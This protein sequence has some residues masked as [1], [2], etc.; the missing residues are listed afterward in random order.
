MSPPP[1]ATALSKS[2]GKKRQVDAVGDRATSSPKP[3]M[4]TRQKRVLPSRTRRGGLGIGSTNVDQMILDAQL[5]RFED[6]PL[7]PAETKFVFTTDSSLVP[8]SSTSD[9]FKVELNTTAY[10]RYFDRPEVIAACRAQETIQVPHYINLSDDAAVGGRFRP[11]GSQEETVDT[12]DSVYEKRH[13]KYEAFEKRQ[14]LREKEKL[15][16]EHYK[17]KERIDQLRNMEISAFLALPASSF[18]APPPRYDEL[19]EELSSAAGYPH[20]IA[21][22]QEG[23]RRRREML[24]IAEGLEERYRILLPPDRPRAAEKKISVAKDVSTPTTPSVDQQQTFSSE[25]P[26]KKQQSRDDAKRQQ[27]IKQDSVNGSKFV[28]RT[29]KITLDEEEPVSPARKPQKSRQRAQGPKRNHPPDTAADAAASLVNAI[30]R[31]FGHPPG[32]VKQRSLDATSVGTPDAGS[33]VGNEPQDAAPR[34]GD[35]ETEYES[36]EALYGDGKANGVMLTIKVPAKESSGSDRTTPAPASAGPASTTR[37]RRQAP[38]SAPV[39]SPYSPAMKRNMTNHPRVLQVLAGKAIRGANGRFLSAAEMAELDNKEAEDIPLETISAPQPRKKR[40]ASHISLSENR[41]ASIISGAE[42]SISVGTRARNR[43]AGP[44]CLVLAAMRKSAAAKERQGGRNAFG[45]RIPSGVDKIHEFA[46][47]Y[48][49]RYPDGEEDELE[50]DSESPKAMEIDDTAPGD[51]ASTGRATPEAPLGHARM[52]DY[53][54][55]NAKGNISMPSM[56]PG[57]DEG[58]PQVQGPVPGHSMS[59]VRG[60]EPEVE[61]MTLSVGE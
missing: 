2:Q 53:E 46:L 11:R 3:T 38:M 35:G 13:R 16:H 44:G 33:I 19:S 7:I 50:P 36:E 18:S 57:R 48:W 6:K 4:Q 20:S 54:E 40:R 42:E 12:S 47:P 23:E 45:A 41:T 21:S 5:R 56:T 26:E 28:K 51:S 60:P 59:E 43:A 31:Q 30:N 32:R 61:S 22:I 49:V 27:V 15:K 55:A 9:T 52:N 58:N 34:V 24:Q 39:R 8:S 10:G 1:A 37:R 17:L 14:R 29:E 25:R